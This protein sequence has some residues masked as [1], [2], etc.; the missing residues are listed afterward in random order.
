MMYTYK[1]MKQ[2]KKKKSEITKSYIYEG[3]I[4]LFSRKG[5]EKTTIRDLARELNISLGIVYYHFKSKDDILIH[6]F[7][8]L[9]EKT[10]ER[11]TEVLRSDA[12]SAVKL[13]AVIEVNLGLLQENE[14]IT[15]DLINTISNISHPLSP[16]GSELQSYQIGAVE[17]FRQAL[18]KDHKPGDYLD[19]VAFL[20]WFYHLGLCLCWANDKSENNRNTMRLFELTFPLTRRLVTITK[21]GMGR[22]L[23][24]NIAELLKSILLRWESDI[25]TVDHLKNS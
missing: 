12:S 2:E 16:F 15:R 5:F 17:L 4:E 3:A 6:Y 10:V 20:Y 11:V 1:A 19:H 7:R 22:K 9:H 18:A 23:A 8:V 13:K 25:P 21:I 14:T 24:M